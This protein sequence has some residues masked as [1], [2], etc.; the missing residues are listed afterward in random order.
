[1][2]KETREI[3][4]SIARRALPFSAFRNESEWDATLVFLANKINDA[5]LA[6]RERCAGIA[7]S[8]DFTH[9]SGYRCHRGQFIA[10]KIRQESTDAKTSRD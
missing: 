3:A 7:E 8:D 5:L 4:E 10:A 6:E 9:S 1:M 2:S